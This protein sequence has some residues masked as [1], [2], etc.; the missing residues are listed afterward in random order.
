MHGHADTAAD[1]LT[2]F[3]EEVRLNFGND[4][5]KLGL[6]GFPCGQEQVRRAARGCAELMPF[7]S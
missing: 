6:L 3:P 5:F 2:F 1:E 7:R 4:L